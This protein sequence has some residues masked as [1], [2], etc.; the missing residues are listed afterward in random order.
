MELFF[1]FSLYG[2]IYFGG[3]KKNDIK[4][5]DNLI[6]VI[7]MMM[8]IMTIINQTTAPITTSKSDTSGSFYY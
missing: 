1:L 4:D 3:D 5:N 6:R 8:V 2:E 7:V